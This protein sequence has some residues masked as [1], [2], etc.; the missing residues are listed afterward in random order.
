MRKP[1]HPIAMFVL[2]VLAVIGI[3]V[4]VHASTWQKPIPFSNKLTRSTASS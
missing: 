4:G 3:G 2:S 1:G